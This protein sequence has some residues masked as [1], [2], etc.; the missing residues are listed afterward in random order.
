[1][2]RRSSANLPVSIDWGETNSEH[3]SASDLETALAILKTGDFQS[4]WDAA[5]VIPTFG[6]AAIAPLLDLLEAEAADEAELPWFVAKILGNL[7]HPAAIDSLVR[8]L[9]ST[10]QSE[11][12]AIAAV[13]LANYG[14]AAIAPLTALLSQPATQLIAVQA[15]AQVQHPAV[16][17]PLLTVVNDSPADVRSAA[18]EA[19][20]HFYDPAITTALQAALQDP[21][22][23]VRRAAVVALGI[24]AEQGDRQALTEMLSPLLWDLNPEVCRQVTVALGRLGTDAAIEALARGL[25]S[26]HTPIVLRLDIVQALIW[27]GT[28]AA[29]ATLHQFLEASSTN[30]GAANFA[31]E[32][33]I[34]I[35]LGRL[36][37]PEAQRAASQ[38]LLDLLHHQ[39]PVAQT[40]QG[41][42][43]IARS[44][45]QLRD[46]QAVEALIG[47]LSESNAC[48]RLH[49]ISALKQLEA[50]GSYQRLQALKAEAPVL[51]AALRAGVETALQEWQAHA[52]VQ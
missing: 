39:H 41:Q 17:P 3:S 14:S 22:T 23:A 31:V 38:L 34:I 30:S 15:L 20:S 4:R 21:N 44:L 37:N 43:Y 24:Q 11:V 29:L 52:D 27:V 12:T 8:V 47:L 6:E 19:L 5:K 35:A 7:N 28:V 26:A 46:P 18:I 42:Q 2:N 33:A 48:V 50:A 9:Q 36:E 13:A 45:G 16:V 49:A 32:Q 51:S 10:Q 1:M 25:C 40:A